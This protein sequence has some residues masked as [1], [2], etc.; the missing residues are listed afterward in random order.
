MNMKN[1][2]SVT[3]YSTDGEWVDRDEGIATYEA[4]VEK[5]KKGTSEGGHSIIHQVI[6]VAQ[7]DWSRKFK[8]VE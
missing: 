2:D 3:F 4:A 6:Q 5:A 7:V 1:T 8:I